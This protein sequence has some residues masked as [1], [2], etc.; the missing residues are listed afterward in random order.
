MKKFPL[1]PQGFTDM[2]TE[3]YLRD[4]TALLKEAVAVASDFLSWTALHFELE[5]YLLEELRS[6]PE[7]LR[8]QLGWCLAASLIGRRP[9]RLEVEEDDFIIQNLPFK[10]AFAV[11]SDNFGAN[12]HGRTIID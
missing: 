1:S 6:L 5:V 10:I 4:D 11:A 7:T 9:V 12:E 3:L 2:L 8:L